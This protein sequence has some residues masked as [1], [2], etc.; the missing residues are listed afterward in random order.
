MKEAKI[1]GSEI[2][3]LRTLISEGKNAMLRDAIDHSV[4]PSLDPH[5]LLKAWML[6]VW[7]SDREILIAAIDNAAK[8]FTEKGSK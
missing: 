3:R 8:S 1:E 7:L 4:S 6:K 5:R 2:D